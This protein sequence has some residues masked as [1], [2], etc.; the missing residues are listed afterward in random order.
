MKKNYLS[1]L[2]I[3]ILLLVLYFSCLQEE[4]NLRVVI[5]FQYHSGQGLSN[6][7]ESYANKI[8]VSVYGNNMTPVRKSIDFPSSPEW[9]CYRDGG[10]YEPDS[11]GSWGGDAYLLPQ[12]ESQ[13]RQLARVKLP[14]NVPVGSSRSIVVET[15]GKKGNVTFRGSVSDLTVDKDT[16]VNIEIN[17][18]AKIFFSV[19]EITDVEKS[20]YEL[21]NTGIL[22][23]YYF[24]RG[25]LINGERRNYAILLG[26]HEVSKDKKADLEFNYSGEYLEYDAQSMKSYVYPSLF[27]YYRGENNIISFVVPGLA[28]SIG[29]GLE[30]GKEYEMTMY[31]ALREKIKQNPVL[32]AVTPSQINYTYYEDV[33]HGNWDW[34]YGYV[35]YIHGFS[36]SFVK[37]LRLALKMDFSEKEIIFST[38]PE[39]GEEPFPNEVYDIGRLKDIE[40]EVYM[41]FKNIFLPNFDGNLPA[42]TSGEITVWMEFLTSDGKSFRTNEAKI[43]YNILK[44]SSKPLDAGVQDV[45]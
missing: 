22:R 2:G 37:T 28:E 33:G 17:P 7:I 29:V 35:S 10:Y 27:G 11:S 19:F 20:R 44:V 5:S 41:G 43:R 4:G 26:E 38:D 40:D 15:I 9:V 45:Q 24:E 23:A 39:D 12:C 1:F 30:P 31:A 16:E 36:E 3:L 32:T 21:A 6:F 8:V 14:L 13:E 34:L 25:K 42:K 18:I